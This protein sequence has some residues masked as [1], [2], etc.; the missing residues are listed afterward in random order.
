MSNLIRHRWD[1]GAV[2]WTEDDLQMAI[3]RELRRR[4]TVFAADFNAG[5]RNPGRAQAMG[6]TAGEPDLRLY[7]PG[8]RLL[9]VELKTDRGTV[10]KAQK[11]RH[12]T[13]TET[14]FDVR[15]LRAATPAEAVDKIATMLGDGNG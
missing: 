2:R 13:L 5:K 9:L 7:L 6:L 3:V 8:G 14:G 1:D 10:S 11:D 15:V 12:R 4:G